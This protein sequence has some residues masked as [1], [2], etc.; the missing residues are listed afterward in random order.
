MDM[1]DMTPFIRQYLDIFNS[2]LPRLGTETKSHNE[3]SDLLSLHTTNFGLSYN[4]FR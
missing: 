2:V 3:M 1:N 4:S